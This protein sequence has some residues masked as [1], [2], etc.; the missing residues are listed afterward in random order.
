MAIEVL[1]TVLFSVCAKA[2]NKKEILFDMKII[3]GRLNI[4]ANKISR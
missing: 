2:M 3:I 4:I 1:E